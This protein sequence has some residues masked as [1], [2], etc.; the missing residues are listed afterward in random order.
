MLQTLK[1]IALFNALLVILEVAAY[2][3]LFQKAYYFPRAIVLLLVVQWI[4]LFVFGFILFIFWIIRMLQ[5][6]THYFVMKKLIHTTL[7]LLIIPWIIALHIVISQMMTYSPN[8]NG[9]AEIVDVEINNSTQY[10]SVRGTHHEN[11][12][13]LFLSGGPGGAQMPATREFLADLEEDYTIINWDQPGT[14]KSYDAIY[15]YDQMTPE[16]YIL[17][18]HQLTDHL[19]Q[20]Y[21]QE[22]I[23]LIG[24]SWGSY[25]AMELAYQY[26]EDYYAVIGTGQMV[27]FT[28]TE[29]DCYQFTLDL[30]RENNDEA[31][32]TRLEELGEPP[33]DGTGLSLRMNAYLT[34]IYMWMGMHQD[35]THQDWDTFDILI[36]P[37][38]SIWDSVGFVMGLLRTFEMI[39]PQLYERDLRET[40][41]E[42]SIP[43]Y[44][45]QGKYDM[46]APT[47]LAQDYMNQIHAPQK[48]IVIFE[49]SGHNPWIDEYERFNDE[50]RLKFQEHLYHA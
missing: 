8:S 10:Y 20:A 45:F 25:L 21:N 28:Q 5:S 13:I 17:D 31:L 24:E 40:H 3:F 1:R 16:H 29:K 11:P 49:H 6:K 35:I 34:P 30:A 27:D 14:G 37:E 12:V 48:E 7:W 23:Y 39:Y 43:V 36:S 41:T 38:Y 47:Y 22:K 46:N 50:V 19:K 26:P 15:R 42:F 32:I 2:L 4:F 44:I 33:Y 18:A 9:I